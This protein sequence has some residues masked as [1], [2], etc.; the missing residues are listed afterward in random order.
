MNALGVGLATP[1]MVHSCTI[2]NNSY[3]NVRVHISYK[4]LPREDTGVHQEIY[5]AN[6]PMGGTFRAQERI[7]DHGSYQTR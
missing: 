1:R 2:K 3:G 7:V 6:I 5:K 4:G